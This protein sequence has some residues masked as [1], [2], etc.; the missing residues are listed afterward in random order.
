VPQLRKK[1]LIV[2]DE[3]DTLT[4][5]ARLLRRLE[6]EID[7]AVS[8]DDAATAIDGRTYQL[9]ITDLRLTPVTGEEGLDVLRRARQKSSSTEVIIL[10]GYGNPAVMTRAF[11]LGAAYYFEKPV[12]SEQLLDA[13]E[14]LC[15]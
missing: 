14:E 4:A 9:I 3:R 2:D 5:L 6:C 12:R 13:V 15:R 8:F 10:T 1:I 11:N 7:V